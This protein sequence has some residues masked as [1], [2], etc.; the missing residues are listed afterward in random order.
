MA[1]TSFALLLALGA[2]AVGGAL[3]GQRRN[4]QGGSGGVGAVNVFERWPRA[5]RRRALRPRRRGDA[6]AA[7]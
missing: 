6:M 1:R 7:A 3:L 2:Y 4:Q 5:A